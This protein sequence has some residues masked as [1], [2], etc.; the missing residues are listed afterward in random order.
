MPSFHKHELPSL[1]VLPPAKRR[2]IAYPFVSFPTQEHNQFFLFFNPEPTHCHTSKEDE[3][4]SAGLLDI[5]GSR[6]RTPAHAQHC[7]TK[8]TPAPLSSVSS[9][10]D[11]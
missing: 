5:P 10:C 7:S 11:N 6:G 9:F 3:T 1:F 4:A 2:K 8:H